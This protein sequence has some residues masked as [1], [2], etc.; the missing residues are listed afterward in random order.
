[1]LKAMIAA[2]SAGLLAAACTNPFKADPGVAPG[3]VATDATSATSHG[4]TARWDTKAEGAAWTALHDHGAALVASTPGDID[5]YCPT[6]REA[7]VSARTAFWVGLMSTLA[8]YESNYDPTVKFTEPF[9]D[10][11]GQPV[12]SRGLLQISRESANGYGCG[13]GNAEELHDPQTNLSCAVRILNKL[14]VR[15]GVIAAK[16]GTKWQ[17]AS[18]YWSPFRRA[19]SLA[20]MKSWVGAQDYCA[21]T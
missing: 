2:L 13:I 6:Y 10:S 12:V 5:A 15:D 18:A 14:V 20:D 21:K 4:W 17:G 8:K 3:A 11:T 9:A 16:V 7:G 19:D 1:M